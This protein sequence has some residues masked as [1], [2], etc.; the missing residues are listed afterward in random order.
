MNLVARFLRILLKF[1]LPLSLLLVPAMAIYGA[2]V[3][4]P[5]IQGT[6]SGYRGQ[7]PI[8]VGGSYRAIHT[9]ST[10][11]V[12]VARSYILFPAVLSDP[13]L[14]SFSQENDNPVSLS[15]S[16]SALFLG[17]SWLILCAIGTW[18]FWFRR[19]PPNNSSKPTPLRGAA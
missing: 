5:A 15:E 1:G 8:Q 12:W 7:T 17:L 10:S 9:T 16:R 6:L 19:A 18:W 11:N 2:L 4:W 14:V 13:K 3:P